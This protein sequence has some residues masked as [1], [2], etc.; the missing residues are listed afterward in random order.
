LLLRVLH[1]LP[2]GLKGSLRFKS[3]SGGSISLPPNLFIS[4]GSREG[5]LRFFFPQN[6]SISILN[7]L[8]V[9]HRLLCN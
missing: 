1:F 5:Y 4:L 6:L 3:S 9:C 7:E 2:C 8:F